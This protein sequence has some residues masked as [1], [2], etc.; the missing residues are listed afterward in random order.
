M[1]A[2]PPCRDC[3]RQI[4][5]GSTGGHCG[6]CHRSFRGEKAFDAHLIRRNDGSGR[7]DCA[8]DMNA[9]PKAS[10]GVHPYWQDDAGV[11]HYGARMTEEDKRKAGWI[12]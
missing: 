2:H 10:G 8:A 3:R 9:I 5:N 1:T 7:S 12:K 4:P 11:W 6:K